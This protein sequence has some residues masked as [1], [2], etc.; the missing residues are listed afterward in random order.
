MSLSK[1]SG[2][3]K[4]DLNH[5]APA[6]ANVKLGDRLDDLIT[7]HNVLIAKFN[8]L[9][10]ALGAGGSTVP[11]L[12]VPQALPA[13]VAIVALNSNAAPELFGDRP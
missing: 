13:P 10:T 4:H 1:G 9:M 6:A 12:T 11:S 3:P 5:M 8:A 2:N 7:Q